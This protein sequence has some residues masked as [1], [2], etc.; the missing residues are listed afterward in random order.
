MPKSGLFSRKKKN[1]KNVKPP[2]R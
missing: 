2:K 1:K